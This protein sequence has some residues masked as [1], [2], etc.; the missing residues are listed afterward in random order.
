[1]ETGRMVGVVEE[2]A[3][4][5]ESVLLTTLLNESNAVSCS[6]TPIEARIRRSM[7]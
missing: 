7:H 5:C 1:M 6:V 4:T 2:E 3:W